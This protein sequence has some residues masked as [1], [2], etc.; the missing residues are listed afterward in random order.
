MT[1]L[2]TKRIIKSGVT[3]FKRSGLVSFASVLVVTITLSVIAAILLIQATLS[4]SLS[5]IENKV[6]ITIYF[7]TAAPETQILSLKSSIEKFPEVA[8]V[9]YISSAQALADFRTKHGD[10]YLT[11]QALD[12]LS[13]NPLGASLTVKARETG[14]YESIVK[15][16][17]GDGALAKDNAAIIDKINYNQNK[18]VIDRLTSII[19]GARRL[20]IILTAVLVL[21]S[22]LITFNTIRLTIYF[23]RE[24]ISVMRLVGADNRYIRGP[25]MIEGVLYGA[26]STL[27]TAVL[28]FGITLWFGHSM[29]EFLGINL[30]TYYLHNFFQIFLIILLSG[31]V[32]GSISSYLAIRRYLKQ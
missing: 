27:I 20:G 26:V 1:L 6:D 3:N 32:L 22:I 24:E 16:L 5:S 17:E 30:F 23:A 14:Q 29:T 21:I 25:F 7:T 10:D 28:F 15:L 12:E 19:A 2:D 18:L 9:S 11:I 31:V 13:D 8:D 4:A